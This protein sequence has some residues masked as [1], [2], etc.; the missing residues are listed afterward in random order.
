MT[1]QQLPVW[2]LPAFFSTF[3]V[4]AAYLAC[5]FGLETR[6][7]A[8]RDRFGDEK[9]FSFSGASP[10]QVFK[11]LRFV[12]SDRHLALRD[13]LA[14]ALTWAVRILF[15][16]SLAGTSAVVVLFAVML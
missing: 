12:Y 9:S 5:T 10:V 14:S 6:L 1:A 16:V 3:V 2:F 15:M 13:S 4:N 8:I 7:N 11:M